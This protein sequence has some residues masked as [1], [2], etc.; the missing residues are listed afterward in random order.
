MRCSPKPNNTVGVGDF[1]HNNIEYNRI[2]TSFPRSRY[3]SLVHELANGIIRFGEQHIRSA[4]HTYLLEPSQE[5]WA[6]RGTAWWLLFS[7]IMV[8]PNLIRRAHPYVYPTGQKI[9]R[10]EPGWSSVLIPNSDQ[11]GLRKIPILL[12]FLILWVCPI[13]R[14]FAQSNLVGV[15]YT[16]SPW[17]RTVD[18]LPRRAYIRMPPPSSGNSNGG[19]SWYWT[20]GVIILSPYI[21]IVLDHVSFFFFFFKWH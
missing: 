13:S 1:I 4:T 14:Y 6:Y 7:S 8:Y 5:Q 20:K 16:W 15:G 12:H 18:L 19:K 9:D 21:L 11:V 2:P 3:T 17:L 10:A